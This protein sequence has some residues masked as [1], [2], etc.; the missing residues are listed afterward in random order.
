MQ[1]NAFGNFFFYLNSSNAKLCSLKYTL[2]R[3][4]KTD[5]FFRA[6]HFPEVARAQWL[7]LDE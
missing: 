4:E 6:F 1:P 7:G 3:G 5:Q 2:G